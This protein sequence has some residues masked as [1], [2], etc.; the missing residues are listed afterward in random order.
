MLDQ[1]LDLEQVILDL[2]GDPQLVHRPI[3]DL[4]SRL[5]PSREAP[6]RELRGTGREL[7]GILD[8]IREGSG[9]PG[10]ILDLRR[11]G[12]DAVARA[13]R[14][15]RDRILT[16]P[17]FTLRL[18][19]LSDLHERGSREKEIWRKRRVLGDEWLRH[20]ETIQDDGPIHLVCFTG[21]AADW[22]LAEE[23]EKATELFAA[24]LDALS[25]SWDHFFVVPGNHDIHRKTEEAT[26]KRLRPATLSLPRL[27]ASRWVAGRNLDRRFGATQ[28]EKLLAR[29]ANY[30]SWLTTIGRAD[31]LP[32]PALHPHLG[33]R[34]TLRFPGHPFDFHVIGL[35]SAWLCGDNHDAD[36]LLLTQDQIGELCTGPDG[37]PLPGY[38]LVLIHHPLDHLA[39]AAEARRLLGG[40]VDLLLRGHLHEPEVSTWADPD[41][42]LRQIAAGCLYEGH[43]AD[44][45][46]N[47]CEVVEIRLDETGRPLRYDLRFRGWSPRGFWFDDGSLYKESKGGRL[48][49]KV[50]GRVPPPDLRPQVKEVFVGREKELAELQALL[51][52]PTPDDRPVAICAI[53]GMPGV[54]KSYLADRFASEFSAAFQG[55]I[56]RLVFD[57]KKPAR[58]EDLLRDLADRLD[59]PGGGPDLAEAVRERLLRPRTLL[60]VENVDSPAFE[61]EATRFL[62]QLSG[63]A[64]LVTGRVWDLGRGAG[65]RQ[66]RIEP[67]DEDLA[68]QQLWKEIGRA[69]SRDEERE[70]R[71][72]LRA[73]GGLPLAVHLAAGYLRAGRTAKGFLQHLRDRGLALEPV[74]AGELAVETSE[75]ARKIL[76]ASFGIS[77]D[78][79]AAELDSD[80]E[81]RLLNG[82]QA[83][84]H[85]PLSGFGR[86]LGAAIAGLP[87]D[88]FEEVVVQARRLSLLLPISPEERPDGAWRIHPLLAELLRRGTDA[89]AAFARMTKWFVKRL[90]E[91]K[92]A[93]KKKAAGGGERSSTRRRPWLYGCP[94][95]RE[96]C[97]ST[98]NASDRG[99]PGTAAPSDSGWTSAKS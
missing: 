91:P 33:Y 42:Q 63:C 6:G 56:F 55:G 69:P 60:H 24:T 4:Q 44:Q 74:H 45:Y 51:L 40:R 18:L 83:L 50:A 36:K 99:L 67:F 35:D 43:G 10:V 28:R 39:D 72:L 30:R 32:D 23:F 11:G 92:P 41:R 64:T 87:E 85:A 25:L 31:L 97:G 1:F 2:N 52:S 7:L 98:S 16:V 54:G 89:S 46:P 57:P 77:L 61:L 66:V 73:L 37:N 20:L 59:I 26:W 12:W 81:E 15:A 8:L 22:G 93:K 82:F 96:T 14:A 9:C 17:D 34:Q 5:T 68:L 47:A 3:L 88:D 65:W 78:L 19:H 84:G 49:W 21:D 53:E 70:Y 48:T 13:A 79:L 27:D 71:E 76:S 95:F 94:S 86:S 58:A 62:R 38:R 90:P 75:A 29:Q 80:D